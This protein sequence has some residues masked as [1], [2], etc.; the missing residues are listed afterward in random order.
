M[1]RLKSKVANILLI[2]II[3]IYFENL[4]TN[5]LL[6]NKNCENALDV[7]WY[8]DASDLHVPNAPN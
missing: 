3:S 8:Q 2:F 5:E 4:S 6:S 7:K 1:Q